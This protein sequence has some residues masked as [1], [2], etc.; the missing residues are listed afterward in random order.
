MIRPSKSKIPDYILGDDTLFVQQQ[1]A[2]GRLLRRAFSPRLVGKGFT[3]TVK[4]PP[5]RGGMFIA[6]FFLLSCFFV[7]SR[8]L[9]LKIFYVNARRG[10]G[11]PKFG[12]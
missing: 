8:G 6:V 3:R 9:Q 7:T 11:E 12:P 5:L 1:V 4:N 10:N 2:C